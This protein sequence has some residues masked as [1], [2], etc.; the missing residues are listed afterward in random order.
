MR[1]KV[2]QLLGDF[3]TLIEEGDRIM[4]CISGGKDSYAMLDV[5]LEMQKRSPVKYEL[6]AVNIDQGWPGYDTPQIEAHLKGTG[7]EYR[8]ITEDYAEIVEGM[9]KPGQTPCTLCSR[10]RRGVLYN[11]AEKLGCSKIALGH[12]ADDLIETLIMNLFYS[13]RL[14]SMPPLLHSDDGRNT[15]I[16]PLALVSEAVLIEYNEIRKFPV[17]RCGCPSCGL[18]AQKRQV[19]KRLLGSLEKDDPQIKTHM[20]AALRNVVPDHLMDA[21]ITRNGAKDS[22]SRSI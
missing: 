8:M 5:L 12:H 15:V 6:I 13:G 9:L 17:V 21:S 16:R 1:K 20:L 22:T 4:V 2:G 3:P 19:I 10:F 11:L 18:P 14:A 7:V